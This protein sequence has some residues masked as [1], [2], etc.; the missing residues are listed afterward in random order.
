MR[1]FSELGS[2]KS[3]VGKLRWHYGYTQIYQLPK[4]VDIK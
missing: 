4:S 2:P 3:A 1:E